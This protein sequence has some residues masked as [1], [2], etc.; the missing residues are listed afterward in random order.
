MFDKL[1]EIIFRFAAF[2][3]FFMVLRVFQGGVI[4]RL[5]KFH[6]LAKLGLNWI[7]PFSIEEVHT[8][9]TVIETMI[10]GP[11]SLITKDGKEIIV[12]TMATFRVIDAKVFLLEIEG[13]NRVIEDSAFGEVAAWVTE[14]SY[15]ELLKADITARLTT[16]LRK[17]ARAYG[18]EIIRVQLVDLTKSRSIRLMQSVTNSYT[19]EF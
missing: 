19:K 14:Q 4:L 5:G 18:V 11:Q 8:T 12:T 10:I 6:R 7:W 16:R 3:Q 1:F 15:E 13:A 2:F 17:R 9:N